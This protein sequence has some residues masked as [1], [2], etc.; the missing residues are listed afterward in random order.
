M[1]L[2]PQ[3][4]DEFQKVFGGPAPPRNLR[5]PRLVIDVDNVI[6]AMNDEEHHQYIKNIEFLKTIDLEQM[7]ADLQSLQQGDAD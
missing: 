7:L 5:N 4:T 1:P 6:C 3:M 2:S